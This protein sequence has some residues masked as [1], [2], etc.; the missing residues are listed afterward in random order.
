MWVCKKYKLGNCLVV[1]KI[2]KKLKVIGQIQSSF[3][4]SNCFCP[5]ITT[6]LTRAP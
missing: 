5:A 1:K 2:D 4:L 6:K 3:K